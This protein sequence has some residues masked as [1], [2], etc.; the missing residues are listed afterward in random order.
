MFI[1]C[2]QQ[3]NLW[4]VCLAIH[5]VLQMWCV[6]SRWTVQKLYQ[7]FK[8][9]EILA[10]LRH[11]FKTNSWIGESYVEWRSEDSIHFSR[12]KCP[13]NRCFFFFLFSFLFFSFFLGGG[14]GSILFTFQML[15]A[16]LVSSPEP[17]YP[18]SPLPVS[19]RVIAHPPPTPAS[20]TWGIEPSL[21]QGPLHPLM[22][23]KSILYYRC[24]WSHG[25]CHVYSF[26]G[27]LDP[28]S[29]G[30]GQVGWYCCSSYEITNPFSFFCP[31]S[32]SSI[33]DPVLSPMVGCKHLPLYLSGSG[34]PSEETV[35]SGSCQQ[36]LLGILKSVW[37][38][39]LYM[40]WIPR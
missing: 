33:G 34:R 16:F 9:W 7:M 32:N 37:V 14:R 29:S 11:N 39:W 24:S 31:F 2:G 15:S 38:W 36:A 20:S 12:R 40:G 21:D 35:I 19:L 25:S 8:V 28:G 22:P 17:P 4:Q 18:I 23:N 10:H 5:H 3:A 6:E 1:N 26:V 13:P 27:G 30:R